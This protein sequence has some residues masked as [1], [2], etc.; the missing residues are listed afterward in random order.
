MAFYA[1]GKRARGILRIAELVTA[2]ERAGRDGFVDTPGCCLLRGRMIIDLD[3]SR[4]PEKRAIMRFRD[5]NVVLIPS[6]FFS[7]CLCSGPLV[8]RLLLFRRGPISAFDLD[9]FN[10]AS[11][12]TART[13]RGIFK[14]KRLSDLSIWQKVTQQ[15]AATYPGVSSQPQVGETQL[16]TSDLTQVGRQRRWQ[17]PATPRHETRQIDCIDF[18]PFGSSF[19]ASASSSFDLRRSHSLC[20]DPQYL[21]TVSLSSSYPSSTTRLPRLRHDPHHFQHN[22][23]PTPFRLDA[24]HP[25]HLHQRPQRPRPLR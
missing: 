12:L 16:P 15:M 21:K 22:G 13:G 8:S 24:P 14:R 20:P 25:L 19:N 10:G 6:L 5:F 9:C 1:A 4:R 3:S 18:N 2:S 7:T 11:T 23:P 17:S